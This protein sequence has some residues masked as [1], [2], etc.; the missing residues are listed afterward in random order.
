M[1]AWCGK[2]QGKGDDVFFLCISV[3]GG[4][5]GYQRYVGKKEEGRIW[6]AGEAVC[7][8]RPFGAGSLPAGRD[9][10]LGEAV[11]RN[12]SF[13]QEFSNKTSLQY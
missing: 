11:T 8:E 13:L 7:G 4:T 2:R 1:G 3:K 6:R 10:G 5:P 9:K 12:Y